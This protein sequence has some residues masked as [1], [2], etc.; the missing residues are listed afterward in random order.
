[1]REVSKL[2][3]LDIGEG[4]PILLLHGFCGNKEY[5]QEIVPLLQS[6]RRVIAVD[7]SGH[8]DSRIVDG[9]YSVEGYAAEIYQLIEQLSLSKVYLIGHSLGGYITLAF[10]EIYP[11][12]LAGIAIVHSTAFPDDEKGKAG[13]DASIQKI[14]NE[15]IA[16][17]VD[18]LIPKLFAEDDHVGIQIAKE[19]GYKTNPKGAISALNAMRDRPDRNHV[20]KNSELPILLVA[21]GKDRVISPEKTF[22]VS[23]PYTQELLLKNSGHMGML[24]DPVKLASE[25]ISFTE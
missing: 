9:E 2:S 10:A 19:I 3:Y 24:E 15:G 5:W 11:E 13:R 12:K 21:G 17:F 6:H 7:L 23:T 1:M 16:V 20:L 8:G 25:L 18:G 4:N 14:N 22:S